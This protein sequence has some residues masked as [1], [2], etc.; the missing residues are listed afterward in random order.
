MRKQ[1]WR[2]GGTRA[3]NHDVDVV[4]GIPYRSKHGGVGGRTVYEEGDFVPLRQ[5]AF[6]HRL[7]D[8]DIALQHVRRL[9]GPLKALHQGF[10]LFEG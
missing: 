8:G 6:T 3:D 4:R 7:Y 5:R 2:L 9:D 10:A 1:R